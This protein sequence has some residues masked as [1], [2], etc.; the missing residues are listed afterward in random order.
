ME[1]LEGDLELL[2][3]AHKS[4]MDTAAAELASV[5]EACVSFNNPSLFSADLHIDKVL[6]N[7]QDHS[8]ILIFC[9]GCA[10]WMPGVGNILTWVQLTQDK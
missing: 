5:Q 1:T 6:Y 8:S 3:G 4:D 2:K 10:A 9:P 7:H